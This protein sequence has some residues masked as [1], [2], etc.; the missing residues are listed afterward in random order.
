MKRNGNGRCGAFAR[1]KNE[2]G[3][4]KGA[5][6]WDAVR[7]K[8]HDFNRMNALRKREENRR[9]TVPGASHHESGGRFV[10][11]KMRRRARNG[12]RT[13]EK[14]GGRRRGAE[15]EGAVMPPSGK[16]EGGSGT[17]ADGGPCGRFAVGEK[18]GD[19]GKAR[20][21]KK[22]IR[23]ALYVG[24]LEEGRRIRYTFQKMQIRAQALEQG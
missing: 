10:R 22:R 7:G 17:P 6:A 3:G 19:A 20:T 12:K 24:I 2:G 8:M 16:G 1:R 15:T 5:D 13:T 9:K 23:P 11:K 4:D 14:S 18:G 21:G